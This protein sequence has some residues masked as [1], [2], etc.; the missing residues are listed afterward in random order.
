MGAVIAEKHHHPTTI[1]STS[2]NKLAGLSGVNTNQQPNANV[3]GDAAGRA[4][5]W[6]WNLGVIRGR[7][8]TNSNAN[9]A[10]TNTLDNDPSQHGYTSTGDGCQLGIWVSRGC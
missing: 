6:K 3:L 5:Q 7:I 8:N 1:L 4:G 9:L 2:A 10:V